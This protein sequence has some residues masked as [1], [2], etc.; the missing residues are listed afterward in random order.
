MDP[1]D[2][3]LST[4]SSHQDDTY[5]DENLF[6]EATNNAT[7]S[8]SYVAAQTPQNDHLNAA[9]PGELS[10]PRSQSISTGAGQ[11]NGFAPATKGA[12][13]GEDDGD[14]ISDDDEAID[15]KGESS[16]TGKDDKERPG[17]GW[18]NKK[19][20]EEMARAW[21]NVVDRDFDIKAYGD[22]LTHKSQK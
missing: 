5:D 1:D 21:E 12:T 16:R 18:K 15:M 19:A 6:P 3:M 7:S 10:P 14:F 11:T 20:Q 2:S 8:T 17:A 13:L 9:A 4:P 22:P